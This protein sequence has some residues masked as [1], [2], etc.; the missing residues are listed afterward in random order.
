MPTKVIKQIQSVKSGAGFT[1]IEVL[2]YIAFFALLVGT[3][4]GIAYQTIAATNQINNKIVLQQEADFI[5]RKIDWALSGAAAASVGSKSSDITISRFSAPNT[6]IFSQDGN[7]IRL[8]SGMGTMDLNS[9][10]VVV[11]NLAF[12]KIQLPLQ[13]TEIQVSFGLANAADP[14]V[15][16]NFQL[17]KYLRQ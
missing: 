1:L 8:D 2:I 11:S 14:S 16:Q 7:Y 5:L 15:I 9:A 10:N 17:V 6:I 4:L 13:P 12:T 3:L